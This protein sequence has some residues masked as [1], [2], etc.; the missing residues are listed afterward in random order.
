MR[1]YEKAKLPITDQFLWD[2][3][4]SVLQSADNVV[5]FLL[6]NKYRQV[7]I[8]MG[9]ENPIF[10]KYRNGRNQQYFSKLIYRL[11]QNNYIRVKSLK[12]K[13]AIIITK[14]GLSKVFKAS[15]KIEE[16][17]K[18]KDGRW[19]MII[20]DIPKNFRKSR[21]LLRSILQNLG[22]K[23]FQHSVWVTPYDVS[24]KTERLLQAY[25][26]DQFVKI[27]LIKEL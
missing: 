27:F 13:K 1:Y 18:R 21:N 6:S 9:R 25:S 19:I 16:K 22:Y 14:E 10:R 3:V 5:D 8:L 7:S 20:F 11:K 12:G 2:V 4:F 15:F 24:D 17:Q 26:L 23:L